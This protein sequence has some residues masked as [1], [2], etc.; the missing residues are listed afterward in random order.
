MTQEVLFFV[1]IA[2]AIIIKVKLFPKVQYRILLIDAL[3]MAILY[4]IDEARLLFLAFYAMGI[5]D[6]L[7]IGRGIILEIRE[8]KVEKEKRKTQEII[9]ILEG[10]VYTLSEHE[11]H[12]IS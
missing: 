1:V 10:V 9:D 5:V 2:I 6:L 7:I 3:G 11:Y 4:N 8:I 12:E